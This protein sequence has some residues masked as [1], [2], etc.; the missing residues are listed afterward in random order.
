MRKVKTGA[1]IVTFNPDIKR[2]EYVLE[3][4]CNQVEKVWIVDNHSADIECIRQITNRYPSAVLIVNEQNIGIAA[5]LNQIFGMA[6]N[7]NFSWILTLDDDSICDTDLIRKLL[8]YTNRKNIGIVCARAIDDAM[9]S[10]G[11]RRRPKAE[12]IEDCITAGALTSIAAWKTVGGFDERMFIDFVDIEFCQRLRQGGYRIIRNSEV[13]VNQKYGNITGK[14]CLPGLTLY[15][16]N[17]APKRIYYSV[18]NQV[19]YI[20]KHRKNINVLRRGAYL[21]GFCG[22]HILFE[23][24]RINTIKAIAEGLVDGFKMQI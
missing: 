18:R 17:Y 24:N 12:F 21:T 7:E 3:A 6:D 15:I 8:P 11:G 4:V 22:K 20:R 1:G 2:F 5:A 23:N 9:G 16:L 10:I 14:V 13:F 19:Y